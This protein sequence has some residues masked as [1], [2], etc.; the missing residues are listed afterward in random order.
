MLKAPVKNNVHPIF[1]RLLRLM[2]LRKRRAAPAPSIPR[3]AAKTPI[4]GTGKFK[5]FSFNIA[6]PHPFQAKKFS[7]LKQTE[8]K[9]DRNRRQLLA[10]ADPPC[11]KKHAKP[12]VYY[13]CNAENAWARGAAIELRPGREPWVKGSNAFQPRRGKAQLLAAGLSPRRG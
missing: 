13:F 2:S 8:I 1:R 11:S 3:V 7:F 5:F 6:S 9:Y 12:V 4:N 10:I